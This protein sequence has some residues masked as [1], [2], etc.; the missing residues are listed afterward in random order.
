LKNE[1]PESFHGKMQDWMFG[2]DICQDVCPWNRFSKPHQQEKFKP[3]QLLQT[4]QKSDWQDLSQDL[5]S[6]IFKKS[7]VKRSKFSGLKRNIDFITQDSDVV[8][9]KANLKL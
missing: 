3:N 5:F 6:E 1:I 4:F 7:P 9:F 8:D 2:C